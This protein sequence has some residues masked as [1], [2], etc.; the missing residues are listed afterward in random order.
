MKDDPR[1]HTN[2]HEQEVTNEKMTDRWKILPFCLLFKR[3][4]ADRQECMS[5]KQK[6]TKEPHL[7]SSLFVMT[8]PTGHLFAGLRIPGLVPASVT[9][10]SP[11]IATVAA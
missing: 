8:Q 6:G 7:C 5:Y 11:E 4:Y 2:G 3:K 10:V 9:P 1:N